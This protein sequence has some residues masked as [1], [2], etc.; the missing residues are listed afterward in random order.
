MRRSSS[1]RDGVMYITGSIRHALA[2]YANSPS[3]THSPQFL[4]QAKLLATLTGL[5]FVIRK[6]NRLLFNRRLASGKQDTQTP[7]LLMWPWPWRDNLDIITWP[8]YSEDV[9]DYQNWT[10]QFRVFD[11]WR[12]VVTLLIL[13]P[14]FALLSPASCLEWVNGSQLIADNL[15][16]VSTH[17][18]ITCDK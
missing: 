9:P 1:H 3:I 11:I 15:S 2:F 10:F 16:V 13:W 7:F 18:R 6:K 14:T 4:K 5:V 12:L 8:R 17:R